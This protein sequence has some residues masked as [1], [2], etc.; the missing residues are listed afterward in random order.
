MKKSKFDIQDGRYGLDLLSESELNKELALTAQRAIDSTGTQ[1]GPSVRERYAVVK[2]YS[3]GDTEIRID[4][5]DHTV[6]ASGSMAKIPKK[7][8]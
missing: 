4:E 1:L 8:K 3:E 2:A 5:T 6:Q 7:A